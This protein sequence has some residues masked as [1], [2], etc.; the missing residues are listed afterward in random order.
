M[1]THLYLEPTAHCS[2]K[3]GNPCIN[4][5]GWSCMEFTSNMPAGILENP[6][7]EALQLH[8]AHGLVHMTEELDGGCIV[9][10]AALASILEVELEA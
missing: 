1:L 4:T 8:H 2:L 10:L 5:R 7:N 3:S 9:L 6:K